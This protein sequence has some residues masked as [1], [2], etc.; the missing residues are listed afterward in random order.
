MKNNYLI[1]CHT[2][3]TGKKYIGQTNNYKKRCE[4]HKNSSKTS[5][6]IFANAIK[7][8]GWDNFNH[9]ILWGGLTLEQANELE[10]FIIQEFNTL[11]PNGYNLTPGGLNHV[12][13]QLTREKISTANKGKP[14][15]NK[16]K[17]MRPRTEEEKE[18]ARKY[19]HTKEA[20]E[21][22]S[23]AL[24]CRIRTP[25]SAETK[26]KISVS[27]KGCPPTLTSFKKGHQLSPE[28]IAK[29]KGR[30]SPFKGKKHSPEAIAKRTASRKLKR[31]LKEIT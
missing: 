3:P 22:I 31:Q 26:E 4:R 17:K 8:H 14:G 12:C 24:K 30:I 11:V 10:P 15:P 25:V 29:L 13:H 1:Y 21:K 9:E 20:K 18:R 5:H 7:K 16:G 23:A 6:R 27:K 2:S 19:R 28:T